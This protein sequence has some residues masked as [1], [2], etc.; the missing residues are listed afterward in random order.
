M[1]V[2]QIVVIIIQNY[3]YFNVFW[4]KK[5]MKRHNNICLF[6]FML[7]NKIKIE[8]DINNNKLLKTIWEHMREINGVGGGI[9]LFI[10]P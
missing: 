10:L 2:I 1:Y 6:M 3:Y 9:Y 8:I 5:N 4:G 7:Y